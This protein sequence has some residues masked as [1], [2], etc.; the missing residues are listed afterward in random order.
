MLSLFWV[1]GMIAGRGGGG[2]GLCGGY[3]CLL[4]LTVALGGGLV[5]QLCARSLPT[6]ERSEGVSPTSEARRELTLSKQQSQQANSASPTVP[7]P[8][9]G[10]RG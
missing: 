10:R 5:R 7:A 9:E 6:T 3:V 4:R 8:A 1:G 2:W